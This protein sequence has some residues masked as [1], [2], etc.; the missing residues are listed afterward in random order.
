MEGRTATALI[1]DTGSP[2]KNSNAQEV[3][4]NFSLM[5]SLK[6]WS[7]LELATSKI[8][9]HMDKFLEVLALMI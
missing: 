5:W 8:N 7:Y 1:T 3:F 4:Y 6:C 2:H 9:I